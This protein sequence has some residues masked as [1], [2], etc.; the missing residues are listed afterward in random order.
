MILYALLVVF[1]WINKNIVFR[2]NL[3]SFWF[4]GLYLV[5]LIGVFYT[6]DSD[7]SLKYLENKLPF[8]FFPFFFCFDTKKIISLPIIVTGLLIGVTVL[9]FI[10]YWKGLVCYGE[11]GALDCFLTIS[12]SLHKDMQFLNSLKSDLKKINF[13]FI[14]GFLS[15]DTTETS[16]P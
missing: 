9:S 14:L 10:G 12:L 15:N 16:A 11:S 5:Y 6:K 8:L 7:Q 3:K 13:P 4:V 2:W 1:G